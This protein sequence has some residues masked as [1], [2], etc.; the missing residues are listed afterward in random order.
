MKSITIKV[1]PDLFTQI[2]KSRRKQFYTKTE[3]V[4]AA[5]R[6]KLL[7]DKIHAIRLLYKG[8]LKQLTAQKRAKILKD[9]GFEWLDESFVQE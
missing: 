9:A 2:E 8:N 5:L 1:E 6:E 7:H 4:R 3:Y